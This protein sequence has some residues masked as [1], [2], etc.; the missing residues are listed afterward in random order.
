MAMDRSNYSKHGVGGAGQEHDG[1]VEEV[2]N[3]LLDQEQVF[4]NC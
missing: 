4:E 1:Q 2:S 3:L